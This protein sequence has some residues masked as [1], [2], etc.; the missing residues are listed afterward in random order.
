MADR[1]R[2]LLPARQ[3]ITG[4]RGES[5]GR[6]VQKL[7]GMAWGAK[8]AGHDMVLTSAGGGVKFESGLAN[9]TPRLRP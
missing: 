9:P 1:R 5:Q 7:Y 6:G 2:P 8:V 3:M 4:D